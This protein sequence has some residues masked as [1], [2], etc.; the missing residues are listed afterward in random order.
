[1]A[2]RRRP[3]LKVFA[4]LQTNLAFIRQAKRRS[5]NQVP[6]QHRI[7]VISQRIHCDRRKKE[8]GQCADSIFEWFMD[9]LHGFSP[10]CYWISPGTHHSFLMLAGLTYVFLQQL[11]I[12]VIW[13]CLLHDLPQKIV[14]AKPGCST[15]VDF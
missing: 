11:Y 9:R 6:R 5:L 8:C 15:P 2:N 4:Q 3:R 7:W 14:M 12:T 13:L 10:V 1:M